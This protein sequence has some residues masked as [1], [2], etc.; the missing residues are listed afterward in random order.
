MRADK[1]YN[2]IVDEREREEDDS[3]RTMNK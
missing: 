1:N 2:Q 3:G